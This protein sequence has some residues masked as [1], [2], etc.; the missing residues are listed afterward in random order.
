MFN[1]QL[2]PSLYDLVKTPSS[3]AMLQHILNDTAKTVT[4]EITEEIQVILPF[5]FLHR[6]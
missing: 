3:G 6:V 4:N 2:L 1:L 5:L